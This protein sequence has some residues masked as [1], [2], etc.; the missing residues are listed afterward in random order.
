[1][2][3]K[4]F[5]MSLVGLA[6]APKLTPARNQSHKIG[7]TI[8][9]PRPAPFVKTIRLTRAYDPYLDQMVT[10][11]DAIYGFNRIGSWTVACDARSGYPF[12]F[13]EIVRV[14]RA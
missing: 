12:H 2:T 7:R 10:R 4:Q 8:T 5:L 6:A 14:E 9:V 13:D 1:M 11:Y 3:R